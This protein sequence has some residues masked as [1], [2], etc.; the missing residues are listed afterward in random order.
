MDYNPSSGVPPGFRI[1]GLSNSFVFDYGPSDAI[2]GDF[3][4]EITLCPW[5]HTEYRN[6]FTFDFAFSVVD[7]L[8]V[9]EEED[10]D[11]DEEESESEEKKDEEK[12]IKDDG[13]DATSLFLG[14]VKS[15]EDIWVDFLVLEAGDLL[16]ETVEDSEVIGE[17]DG[18]YAN[19]SFVIKTVEPAEATS[20]A[21]LTRTDDQQ[22]KFSFGPLS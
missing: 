21:S 22:L 1:A 2:V 19:Y 14:V 10:E 7:E 9:G 13:I 18:E 12:E 6:C 5:Q 4:Y 16:T 8:D 20:L 11:E 3:V 15:L 17:E